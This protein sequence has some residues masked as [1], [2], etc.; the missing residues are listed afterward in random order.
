MRFITRAATL[1][2][3]ATLVVGGLADMAAAKTTTNPVGSLKWCKNHPHSKLAACQKSTGGGTGSG[4]G[5]GAPPPT[6]TI[7]VSPTP[8]VETGQSEI[9]AVVEVETSPSYANDIVNIDS[10]QL[11]AACGGA[12]LFG[13]LQNGINFSSS[14]VQVHLDDDG[15]VTVSLYGLD[16][17]PGTSVIEA[18]LT[19]AP[20]YSALGAVDAVAPAVT[21]AG[22]TGTPANEVETGNSPESGNSDVYAVFYVETDPVYAEQTVELASAQLSSRCL[23]GSTWLSNGGSFPGPAEATA[24]LDNDGN[25]V[26]AF[27]GAGCAAGPSAVI[28]DVLAG[29]H[30]SY[31]TTFTVAAPTPTI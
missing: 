28:A 3:V 22:V 2:A 19:V 7:A 27:S 13:T 15:N 10:S 11:A 9:Y 25:A 6:M 1:V 5:T 20:F 23:G 31:V 18:D 24:T 29:I 17:A 26:F 8:L 4:G 12:I 16:C 21:P 30:S 14:S